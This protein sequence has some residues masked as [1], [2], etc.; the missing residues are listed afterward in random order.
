MLRNY[1]LSI[2]TGSV[3]VFLATGAFFMANVQLPEWSF[4]ISSINVLLFAVPSFWALRMWLGW[5]DAAKLIV[6][7]GFFALGVET[8]AIY[9]G[10]PYGH[11]GYSQHLGYKLFGQVPWTVA[12]AWTPLLLCAYT[13]AR[14]LFVSRLRRVLFSAFLL[15]VFDLV[16]DP[17]A[18]L[19]GF[20]QYPAGGLY[21]GVPLSNFFGWAF[22]GI[23][24]SAIMEAATSF[25][26]PLLPPP[27]QIGSSAFFIV[28][29]W[30]ALA[31]FGGLAVPA[32]IGGALAMA[33]YL[34]YRRSYY[35]FDEMVVLVDEDNNPL[36]TARKSDTHHGDTQLHRAFSV[37]L[38]NEN[39]EL[40]MQRRAFS[41]LTWP[42]VWSNS[43]CG[44]TM[45]NE[46]TEQAAARRLA[47]ELG[48]RGVELKMA[49][50]DYRYRAEKDGVVENEICPVL[51]GFTD[52]VP[53]L[54]PAEVAET[55]WV[56]WEDFLASTRRVDCELS[57]WAV[58]EGLLLDKSPVLRKMLRQTEFRAAA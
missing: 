49:L 31:A 52:Q 11:F 23:V 1:K 9:T 34:W 33:M 2:L 7:L 42:G 3:L 13:A 15:V 6:I 43:C 41:K 4:V 22:S 39:G 54:N 20:W 12:F 29:F 55:K 58:E 45:L 51:V 40:L 57:P 27:V 56:A 44:H 35:A 17:G 37:F 5:T 32:A 53:S 38:F 48:L 50:P 24:G 10:F 16:L 25:F 28:F 36:G 21:Y 30:T 19:L 47:F 8:F 26:K 46:R 14:D 18:V